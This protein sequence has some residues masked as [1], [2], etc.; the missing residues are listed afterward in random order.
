[1]VVDRLHPADDLRPRSRRQGC[2]RGGRGGAAAGEGADQLLE[3]DRDGEDEAHEGERVE[4]D[5]VGL[6]VVPLAPRS[7]VR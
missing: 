1:L 7:P 2:H 5:K 3:A 4:G 6:G